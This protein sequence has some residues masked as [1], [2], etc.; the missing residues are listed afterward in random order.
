[1]ARHANGRDERHHEHGRGAEP[2]QAQRHHAEQPVVAEP[3]LRERGM[4]D[5]AQ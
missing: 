5:T 2:R 3:K 1:L 4:H